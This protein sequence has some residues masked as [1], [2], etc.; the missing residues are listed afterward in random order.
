MNS[1]DDLLK[2]ELPEIIFGHDALSQVGQ[3]AA[4]WV[5]SMFGGDRSGI[6]ATG[7]L[8]SALTYLKAEDLNY[9]VFDNVVS[10]PRDYQVAQGA[11][12]YKQKNCDVI[13]ALGGGSPW[14]WQGRCRAGDQSGRTPGL[15][16]L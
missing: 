6:V 3:C 9:V 13:I 2:F 12:L 15:R 16:G 5:V 8:D 14:M 1:G 7:W 10:N 11:E 4:R